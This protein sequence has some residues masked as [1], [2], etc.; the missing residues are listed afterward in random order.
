MWRNSWSVWIKSV[1]HSE[2]A[3]KLKSDP[4]FNIETSPLWPAL[5]PCEEMVCAILDHGMFDLVS[6]GPPRR[7]HDMTN[8][9]PPAVSRPFPSL[10]ALCTYTPPHVHNR[11]SGCLLQEN[12]FLF[13]SK[14]VRS[15]GPVGACDIW[16][17]QLCTLGSQKSSKSNFTEQSLP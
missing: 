2:F 1:S 17:S 6:N 12:E 8:V 3:L 13:R 4:Q 16:F 7:L 9:Y 11:P 10:S 14:G 5:R 15:P